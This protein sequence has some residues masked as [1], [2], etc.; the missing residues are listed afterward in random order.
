MG[1]GCCSIAD[2]LAGVYGPWMLLYSRLFGRYIWAMDAV[3]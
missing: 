1:H 3:V 2:Y